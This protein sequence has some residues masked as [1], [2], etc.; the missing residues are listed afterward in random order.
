M[1]WRLPLAGTLTCALLVA[2]ASVLGLEELPLAI[3]DA[4]GSDTPSEAVVEV[5]A[6]CDARGP[7]FCQRICPV[8][9]FCEDFEQGDP[10]LTWKAPPSLPNPFAVNGGTAAV[11]V[12][13][14]GNAEG[15][16]LTGRAEGTGS[17]TALGLY[18]HVLAKSVDESPAI[19]GVRMQA[20][21][22]LVEFEFLPPVGGPAGERWV[23]AFALA[24]LGGN[25]EGVTMLLKE[26]ETDHD[27]LLPVLS[28]RGIGNT[29]QTTD[30]VPLPEIPRETIFSNPIEL[31]IMIADKETFEREGIKCTV[32]EPDASPIAPRALIQFLNL[33]QC[34]ALKGGLANMK[35]LEVPA[36]GAGIFVTE[37]TRAEVRVDNIAVYLLR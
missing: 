11:E 9:D 16:V 23:G 7:T 8:P 30:L 1:R 34:A 22:R 27:V 29:G 26:V 31:D 35:W 12:D 25:F 14:A 10:R 18:T 24:G 37:E 6:G 13:D 20:R 17:N 32:I 33:A 3:A 5:D 36:V 28:Q 4:G 2:C 19:R 21:V 15:K